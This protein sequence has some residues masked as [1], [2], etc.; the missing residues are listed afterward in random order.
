MTAW[1]LNMA[2]YE[3]RCS[4]R[5]AHVQRQ[6]VGWGQAVALIEWTIR[7][8]TLGPPV[9]LWET[10]ESNTVG[11]TRPSGRESRRGVYF[12]NKTFFRDSG[13]LST[14]AE[15]KTWSLSGILFVS[16]LG[17]ALNQEG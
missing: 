16:V 10:T 17:S 12:G 9:P 13:S 6:V 15:A 14:P 8:V 1:T 7:R 2:L 4:R 3:G 5:D 11:W